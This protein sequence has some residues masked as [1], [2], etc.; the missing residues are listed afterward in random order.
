MLWLGYACL[1]A[2][3]CC[4][5]A[6]CGVAL[7]LASI[8]LLRGVEEHDVVPISSRVFWA[9]AALAYVK[10]LETAVLVLVYQVRSA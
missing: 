6:S 10:D 5:P 1:C 3:L 7:Q 8:A 4:V 9:L 2:C